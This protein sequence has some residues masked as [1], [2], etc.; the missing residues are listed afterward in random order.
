MKNKKKLSYVAI[1]ADILHEGHINILKVAS[2]YGNVFVGLLTDKAISSYK[3]LPY[4]NFQQRKL[5]VE[6]IKY[7][8][9]VIPQHSLDHTENLQK[10]KPD[11]V[12]HGDD[13]RSGVLKKTRLKVIKT[14]SR[15]GGKLIE[16]KYSKDISLTQFKKKIYEVGSS[17]NIRRERLIRLINSKRIVRILESHSP[18][19][20][21]II[22]KLKIS[23]KNQEC[24]FDGMWSSSLTDS[25][26]RGK[27]DNQAVDYSTRINALGETLDV[28]TK[29][30]IFDADNGGRPEHIAYLIKTIDRLGVSA[31]IIEDK[32]GL[33]K[34]SLFK[35]QSGA[36]Q[37]S[38]NNF[39]K[40]I[41]KASEAKTSSDFLV[42][43]RI[44]SLILNNGMKDA[45]RR[46]D[47]Y[48]QAGAD[49]I[50]IHSKNNSPKEILDFA[51]KFK[52]SKFFKPMVAVP[53]TYSAIKE[54]TLIKYGFKIVIYTNHLLRASYPAMMEVAKKIL[55]NQ[56]SKEIEKKI[57]SVKEILTLIK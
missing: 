54:S 19:T 50:M 22:E 2:K 39:C 27:P 38:I 29:P 14:L 43:A 21:L 11:Y 24:E 36:K 9:K 35:D 33:K 42:I 12:V 31:V 48:S 28:T 34:N 23:V 51:K 17:P 3:Q 52:K 44:E 5:I 20:G 25:T 30:V 41:K 26:L 45:L 55:L 10:I 46:A 7:V 1:S 4:L 53:S 40:K 8:D 6:N 56:R 37:D 16:P 57:I 47:A 13:W 49:M 18:L 15:W 32:S